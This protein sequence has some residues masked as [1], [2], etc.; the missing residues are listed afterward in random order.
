M[1]VIRNLLLAAVGSGLAQTIF[2]QP[3]GLTN[4]V[5]NTTLQFPPSLPVFGYYTTNA[6][7]ALTFTN[8]VCLRTP[9]GETNRLFVLEKRGRVTVITNLA[10]PTRTVLLDL[11]SRVT[12]DTSQGDERGL[13]GMAFH[14]GYAT[15][16]YFYLY[17]S[18]MT[19]SPAGS[20][21]H[22][23]L[24]RFETSAANPNQVDA[25]SEAPLLT[26]R[27]DADNHNGGDL[28]FGPDG[29]LYV[30]L[31]DEGGSGDSWANSQRI[32]KDFWSGILRLDVDS[33]PESP[34]PN[35]HPAIHAGT[36]R[37]PPDN[38]FIGATSFNG[39]P[40]D[41][42]QVRTEF[43]AVGLRNPWRMAFDPVTGHLYCA[44]VGQNTRE[45]L[46]IIV[47]GGNYGWNYREGLIARP[48]SPNP[49]VGF[50]PID[51][52]LDYGRGS[53]TNQGSSVTGGVV[54]RGSRLPQLDGYYIF[55]DYVSGNI[56]RTRY[57]GTNATPF[58]RLAGDTAIA[59]FGIDPANGDI[60]TGDLDNDTVKRLVY[61]PVS[62]GMLP[63][64]LADTGAF[65]N[66][67]NLTPHAGV[68]P[69]DVHVP[70]WSDGA[71][72]TRW[73]SIPNVANRITFRATN[74]WTF[75]ATTIWIQHFDLELTNG[76]P[77]SRRRLETRFLVRSSTTYGLTY[78]WDDSQTNATLV[79][80]AGMDDAFVITEGGT[81]RTQVWHYP[82]RTEC[83]QC[84]VPA[85]NS[86]LGF[87][88]P[89]LNR[90]FDYGG[91]TDNQLRAL[92]NAGYFSAPISNLHAL[93]S[94]APT[95]D[96]RYS[97]EQRVRSYLAANCV[98]CHRGGTFDAQIY[99]AL[100]QTRLVNGALTDPLGDPINNRVIR[101]GS[102]ANSVLLT[103]L[104]TN[105][106]LRMPP[107]GTAQLDTQAIALTSAWI[108]ND[109]R[110]HQTFPDWQLSFFGST[111]APEAQAGADPDGD[112]G[113]NDLEYLTGT[114]PTNRADHWRMG[115]ER[116]GH[117]AQV[118]YPRVANRGFEV[119][120]TTN[121]FNPGAWQFL[122]VAE[123][124]PFFAATNGEARVPDSITN[125]TS[126]YYRVRVY[127]P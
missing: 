64:T 116:T 89:Q 104:A 8:P 12:G 71:L 119:Q 54:Y 51:P 125:S 122:N 7:G 44:D 112:L 127:E 16:R 100:P 94:L 60:L 81:T 15:N 50:T 27:D 120:W 13:L 21:L 48:S 31:G 17:Y 68:V 90:E 92:G 88:T 23:R 52:I 2:A 46:D 72:K 83:L 20:G 34:A 37:V 28:H 74:A 45:E 41:P 121:L 102:L 97:V 67:A 49:P 56:W 66:L 84:H 82:S 114:N 33:R 26:L 113:R 58:V 126:K 109:L 101:P 32:D 14:P 79:P 36:Y 105:G 5:P 95:A 57:D 87:T 47:K 86:A 80:D 124:R 43:Y 69:Y 61:A 63:P 103:R 110:R 10:A 11:T 35:A 42:A 65:T 18:L 115:I 53:G 22:Q 118:V 55:A 91:V 40:V 70:C 76:T 98:S 108:T 93:R 85:L 111:N 1:K 9:P 96:E 59:C 25:A 30:S 77:E 106:P 38:P 4:R 73:F 6:F 3:F 75:P 107:L 99:T 62:G 39:S 117:Q 19:N 29:Y 78:R 24:S 123:N